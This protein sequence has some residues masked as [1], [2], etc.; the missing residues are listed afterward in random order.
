M[1]MNPTI[2]PPLSQTDQF[3]RCIGASK[4]VRWDIDHDVLRGRSFESTEKLLPDAI[5]F[6]D[7]L[8]FLNDDERRFLSQ[9][10]GRTY[11]NMFGL[12]ERFINCKVLELSQDYWTGDQVALEALIR[13]SD[14]ELKH[15]ELFRRI[16]G[17]IAETMPEG[18]RFLPRPN[19]VAEVVLSKSNWA[20]LALTLHIELFTQ[21]HYKRSI[22]PNQE[23][24]PLFKDILFFHWKEESQH[25]RIDE[26]ELRRDHAKATSSEISQ[27]VEDLIA[28][29]AA[30][31]SMVAIQ[32]EADA[33]YF[34]GNIDSALYEEHIATLK[35][36]VLQAYRWQYIFSL[37]ETRF[38]KVLSELL[39][40]AEMLKITQALE[41]LAS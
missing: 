29:V 13:F 9:I 31:D 25:A 17:M 40:S 32:A 7:R 23:L 18:Y 8:E 2:D 15:Q 33:S 27:A 21:A 14:E 28:L 20:V 6:I 38:P 30:V 37:E 12:V 10:Q 39:P 4:K 1:H 35:R 16:E 26:I 22:E 24:S 19:E 36:T 41:S 11:A 5:T 3:A 34:L